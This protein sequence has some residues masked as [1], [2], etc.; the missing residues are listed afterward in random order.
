MCAARASDVSPCDLEVPMCSW[1]YWNLGNNGELRGQRIWVG[2]K[3]VLEGLGGAGNGVWRGRRG[4]LGS[5]GV[6]G[7][8]DP[9]PCVPPQRVLLP[10]GY[11]ESISPNYLQYQ[12]WEALQVLLGTLMGALATPGGAPGLWGWGMVLPPSLGPPSPE[13]CG[14]RR[15]YA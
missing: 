12:C 15:F 14:D 7:V 10:Q 3:G 13:C 6:P 1:D 8:P 2:A 4:D 9:P 11:P 5:L